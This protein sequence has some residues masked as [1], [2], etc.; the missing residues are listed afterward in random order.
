MKSAKPFHRPR[1]RRDQLVGVMVIVAGGMLV[2]L[3]AL[4]GIGA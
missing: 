3:A 4:F 1:W 2:L